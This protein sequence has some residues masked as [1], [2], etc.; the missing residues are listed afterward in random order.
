MSSN[1]YILDNDVQKCLFCDCHFAYY[2][3]CI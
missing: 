1:I 3:I 2:C